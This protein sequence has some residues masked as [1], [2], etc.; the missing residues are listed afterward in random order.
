MADEPVF[1]SLQSPALSRFWSSVLYCLRHY[2]P[3]LLITHPALQPDP[4]ASEAGNF[5]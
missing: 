5:W 4:E 3:N 1:Q 2:T